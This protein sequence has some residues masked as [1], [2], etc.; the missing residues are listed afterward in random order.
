M[1]SA[2]YVAHTQVDD[3]F[4]RLEYNE[5]APLTVDRGPYRLRRQRELEPTDARAIAD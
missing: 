2:L 4:A 5:H 3:P 1:P